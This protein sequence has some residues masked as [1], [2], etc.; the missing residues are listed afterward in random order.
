MVA[1]DV[2]NSGKQ[3]SSEVPDEPG[4]SVNTAELKNDDRRQSEETVRKRERKQEIKV[5]PR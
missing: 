5:K 4:M 2:P 1:E 3:V